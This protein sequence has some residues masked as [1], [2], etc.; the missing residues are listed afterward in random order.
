MSLT[1]FRVPGGRRVVRVALMSV[2]D[3][4]VYRQLSRSFSGE[5]KSPKELLQVFDVVLAAGSDGDTGT[6]GE[7]STTAMMMAK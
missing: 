3:D 2:V 1:I 7:N 4:G 5:F 6:T